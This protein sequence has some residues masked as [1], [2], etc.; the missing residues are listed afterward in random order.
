MACPADSYQLDID[1]ACLPD[2]FL[3]LLA[4][5]CDLTLLQGTIRYMDLIFRD[6]HKVKE[7][8]FHKTE[9][10]LQR[11]RIH[12]IVLIQVKCDHIF[13]TE[14]FFLMKAN[15]FVVDSNGSGACS[16]SK[17]GISV[18]SSSLFYSC[19]YFMCNRIG[20]FI[21]GFI[22]NGGYLLVINSF[23]VC[24]GNLV[25]YSVHILK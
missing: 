14:A 21:T 20:G 23:L 5:G 3:I 11:I 13:K 8:F 10:T 1:P 18:L 7:V 25:C 19:G 17:N 2:F 9:V 15:K 16:Q 12:R 4:V 22:D 24:P 6:I